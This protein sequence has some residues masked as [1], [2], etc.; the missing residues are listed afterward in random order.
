MS[1][2]S[3]LGFDPEQGESGWIPPEL[4]SPEQA[5]I[6]R[7]VMSQVLSF[8]EQNAFGD[9]PLP[10]RALGFDLEMKLFGHIL[11]R[12]HQSI[13]SC[14]P[15]DAPVL[16]ADGTEKPISEVV[17]GDMV[18]THM[19]RARKVK[20]VLPKLTKEK[21]M[22]FRVAGNSRAL[23]VTEQHSL[24]Y[25]YG[26][27][28]WRAA[29]AMKVGDTVLVRANETTKGQDVFAGNRACPLTSVVVMEKAKGYVYDLEVEEDHTFCSNGFVIS[30]C[31]GAGAARAYIDSMVGDVAFRDDAEDVKV[32]FPYATWGMGRKLGGMRGRGGGSYGGAQAKAITQWGMLPADD[33][34]LPKPVVTNNWAKWTAREETEWSWPPSWP[35]AESTIAAD[36]AKFQIVTI[37]NIKT[38]DEAA[39]LK[40]QG[41]GL[42]QASNFGCR[43]MKVKENVLIGT[44]ST[45]WSHQM[46]ISGYMTHPS[47]GRI[48]WIQNQWNDVHGKCP[49]L[50]P[51]GCNGG[52]WVSD[53]TFQSIIDRGEVIG[54]S[55]TKGFPVRKIDWGTLGFG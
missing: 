14:L 42:T 36:A 49:T 51:L 13:G 22:Q 45:S 50:E 4:R 12:I 25:W 27:I 5:E 46:S 9:D 31:V 1:W 35:V 7:E 8:D 2:V 16:M 3:M 28:M 21:L 19:G 23:V 34:R 41:Y 48:W 10:A 6:H 11:P 47:F 40:A 18:V 26:G 33:S 54:H 29:A 53:S 37:A 20:G 38:T 17:K 24:P 15:A 55:N 44:W 43:D 52:F 30:N 39:R 32:P